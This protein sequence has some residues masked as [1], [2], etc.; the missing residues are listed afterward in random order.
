[1]KDNSIEYNNT[2]KRGGLR[3]SDWNMEL[4]YE[5]GVDHRGFFTIDSIDGKPV[6]GYAHST[7]DVIECEE[8]AIR[9]VHQQIDFVC[10]GSTMAEGTEVDGDFAI[11]TDAG[12]YNIPYHI[13]FVRK[14]VE[15]SV[16]PIGD[17]DGFA[18]LYAEN[19]R[20]AREMFF[21]PGFARVFF[22]GEPEKEALYHG[23]MKGRNRNTIVEEFLCTLGYKRPAAIVVE[24]SR[25]IMDAGTVQ[26]NLEIAMDQPG[27]LE[28]EIGSLKDQL[29]INGEARTAF[30]AD[31]FADGKLTVR[32]EKKENHT[33]G[34]D[35]LYIRTLR[36]E[37]MIPVEWWGTLP[38]PEEKIEK[39]RNV[40]IQKA[41]LMHN[42]LYFRTGVIGF[43]DFI[44]ESTQALEDLYFET[45]DIE[46]K[47]YRVHL[48]IMKEEMGDAQKLLAEAEE[49]IAEHPVDALYKNYVLYLHAMYERSPEAISTA[50]V[51]IREY[52]KVTEHKASA[53]WM[54]IYLDREYVYNKRLQFETIK[55]L[56]AEGENS[57]LLF[58]EAC[59]I[60][61]DNPDFM[62]ELGPFEIAVFR[63]GLRYGYISLPLAYQFARLALRLKYYSPSIFGIAKKLYSVE[64]D[65]RFLQLICSLLI[66]GNKATTEYH[67][68]YRSAVE[69]NLKIIGLNEF[70]IRSMD[71][72]TYDKI[73][74]RVLIYFTYS[75]TLDTNERAYLY[76]NV[77]HN[78]EAY[79]EV[80]GAYYAKIP[81]FLEEQLQKG[82]INE[83]LAYLYL[84]FREILLE[85][86]EFA[87]AVCQVLFRQ[88]LICQNKHITGIYVYQPETD[89]EVYYPLSAGTCMPEIVNEKS[90]IYFVD[91]N[92]QR[93]VRDI[94][95]A[96]GYFLG[97]S[98]MKEEWIGKNLSDT[99]VLLAM[100]SRTKQPYQQKDMAVLQRIAFH[101]Q[102]KPYVR[103]KALRSMLSWY[104]AQGDV[105]EL[106]RWLSRTDYEMVTKDYGRT[107]MEHYLFAGMQEKAY[108]GV[109]RHSAF[110]LSGENLLELATYGVAHN[111]EGHEVLH[112]CYSAFLSGYYNNETLYHLMHGFNGEIEDLMTIWERSID[113]NLDTVDFELKILKQSVYT[114]NNSTVSFPV[115]EEC[116]KKEKENPI[117]EKYLNFMCLEELDGNVVLSDSMREV[118]GKEILSGKI[119]G[120]DTKIYYLYYYADKENL[121]ESTIQAVECI[122]REFT[123]RNFYLPVF[124]AYAD[125][126]HLPVEFLEKVYVTYQGDAEADVRLFYQLKEEE[127]IYSVR[128]MEV[129]PG[130]Y[131]GSEHFYTNDKVRYQLEKN[132]E[133][134]EDKNSYHFDAFGYE[135]TE[136][137]FCELNRLAL[138]EESGEELKDYLTR[139][140]FVD[141]VLKTF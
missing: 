57:C 83:Q 125:Y 61:N 1:M 98:E 21:Q 12:E 76:S 32:L 74:Q 66:K 4:T 5:A 112:L 117:L 46:W 101:E 49:Y 27:Y 116:Y 87:R 111:P 105:K 22:K 127:K 73:P 106:N 118:V 60:I 134:V 132:G 96:K 24:T 103:E 58:F 9:G 39:G 41:E 14:S 80:Y 139:A 109:I 15:S 95:H 110:G 130:I 36:Q 115:F 136:S 6:K 42:Y 38:E 10:F 77:L 86:P 79:E 7:N 90:I 137:R 88:R 35:T 67:P 56:F 133:I 17:L 3:L 54:L 92:E 89:Q 70:F 114:A 48:H 43:E 91:S 138:G 51:A 72:N 62:D 84:S 81:A 102:L 99:N 23:F 65:E 107:L 128:M 44:E 50:V 119:N 53:L 16:G 122:I 113:R 45:N 100:G 18:R 94:D 20:E 31:D 131:V 30:S 135:G 123:G 126:V 78:K 82:K 28:G 34:S 8:R 26:V 29:F 93:Y 75:N 68:Y 108:E 141:R 85:R 69:A 37:I 129:L 63:W 40:K 124:H 2:Q 59:E 13:R 104:E 55:Q 25:I 97:L 71:F 11:I 140:F 120:Q 33:V 47:L 64:P 19:M 52:L 121:T